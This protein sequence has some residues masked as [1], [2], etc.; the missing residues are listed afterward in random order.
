MTSF[1][2]YL[3]QG[4]AWLF[5]P[6]AIVL[7][8]LHGLEPGHS[9]TMMAAFIIAIRGTVRQAVLLGFSAT[10]SHTVVIWLLAFVG[11]HYSGRIDPESTEPYFQVIAGVMVIGMAVWMFTRTRRD[12]HD[13]HHHHHRD[14]HGHDGGDRHAHD[15]QP[16]G[17]HGGP[18]VATG[19]NE[20]TEISVFET[21]APPRFR[22]H[23]YDGR[24][25][26]IM[27]PTDH[28]I[29]LETSRRDGSKQVFEFQTQGDCLESTS[30][31]PEPH[32]FQATLIVSRDGGSPVTYC[33][34]FEEEHHN[35]PPD[36]GGE[37]FADA[38]EREHAME[39]EKRFASRNVTTGQLIMFG[40]T[41]GLMPCPAAFAVLLVCLQLKKFTLGFALVVAFSAGLAITLVGVGAIAAISLHH[42]SKRFKGF[43]EIARRAPYISSSVMA[44][45]GIAVAVQGLRHLMK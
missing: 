10:I 5:I 29:T 26:P 11:L 8:A 22:L 44:L 15:Q 45:I 43:G 21:H 33:A 23:F 38:H 2:E 17:S 4:N 39:I 18:L 19:E 7:G 42:A 34:R 3:T 31:I 40:L 30:E 24:L 28:A 36:S 1:H 9:K 41:G 32:E 16:R 27:V 25:Q 37:D 20:R 12:I 6:A 35:H 13:A 14:A